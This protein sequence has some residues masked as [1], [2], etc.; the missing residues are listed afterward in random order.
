[1]TL[2]EITPIIEDKLKFLRMELYDIKFIPAGR[3]SILRVF[4]DKE[5]GVTIDDCEKASR[6]LSML[7][8]VEN[9]SQGPYTLEVSSPGADRP[10]ATQRDFLKVIGQY[11]SLELKSEE[12]Q[13]PVLVGKCVSCIDN[14]L[15]IELDDHSEKQVPLAQIQKAKMDIRFK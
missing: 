11:V 4:I 5:G 7:L 9:F 12:K 3:H 2:E 10:L 6:E 14:A 15:M 13:K 8:D 1:M